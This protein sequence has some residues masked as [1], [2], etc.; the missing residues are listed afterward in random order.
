MGLTDVFIATDQEVTAIFHGWKRPT[1]LLDDFVEKHFTNPFTGTTATIRT[2]IPD[3]QPEPDADAV[4]DGDFRKLPWIDQK[5]LD[6]IR[7]ADLASI[8]IGWDAERS[9]SEIHGRAYIGPP[10]AEVAVCEFPRV[11][12]QRLA[13]LNEH[14]CALRGHEWAIAARKAAGGI[15]NEF[16]RNELTS[17]PES[18]WIARVSD[19]S[20][21]AKRA[22]ADGRSM[23]LWMSP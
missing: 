17:I 6:S 19:L 7:V 5:G 18:D 10:E 13:E 4:L 22:M 16:I 9:S 8:L 14:E 21:L 3:N 23:F 2:L 12:L 20:S 15:P 1:P 11:L